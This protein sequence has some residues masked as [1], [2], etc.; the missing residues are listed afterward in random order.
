[1]RGS[2]LDMLRAVQ[3][4]LFSQP[5]REHFRRLVLEQRHEHRRGLPAVGQHSPNHDR[6][7]FIVLLHP[8]IELSAPE[9][10]S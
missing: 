10:L 4:F 3:F 5:D 2:E 8:R 9:V 7:A 6:S 1:V